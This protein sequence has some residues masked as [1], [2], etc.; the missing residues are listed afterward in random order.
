MQRD[1]HSISS[2]ARDEVLEM[3]RAWVKRAEEDQDVDFGALVLCR[4][5]LNYT[6]TFAGATGC[7]FAAFVALK[8]LQNGIFQ[9][10]KRR[11]RGEDA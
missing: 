11:Q 3:L 8:D 4:G 10:L 1:E 7:E 6:S 5:P 2:A 9:A